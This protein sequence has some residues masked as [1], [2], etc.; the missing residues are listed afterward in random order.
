MTHTAIDLPRLPIGDWCAAVVLWA[1]ENLGPILDA[2]YSVLRAL[3]DKLAAG[4]H[5]V[6]ALLMAVIL[7]LVAWAASSWKLG[8]GTLL[9]MLLISTMGMWDEAMD[10]L[11]LVIVCSVVAMAFALPI[12][13]A[14]ARYE[15]VSHVV[16]PVLDF[17]QTLPVFVYLIPAVLLFGI[18]V[19]PGMVATIVFAMPPG[20][21]LTEL[22]IRQVDR[23]VV[24][25][26]H[27]FGAAP[28]RIL[29]RIQVPLAMPTIMAGVNQVIM[30]ALS[31]VVVAGMVGAG[32]LG[33]LVYQGITTMDMPLGF[34]GG[35]AVVILAMFLD[36][37]T[38]GLAGRSPV[39]RV[40]KATARA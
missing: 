28:R 7:G 6:P 22:G 38:A 27:A 13:V 23:E 3:D 40:S 4:L 1:Q 39:A 37:I 32:G 5:V 16:R 30:L 29:T 14:A 20:V 18:G 31:M 2:I 24:E 21:R 25:A 26:G 34:E 9:G 36:R 35:I 8:V 19:V 12:G 17:M 15:A 33:A 11:S 10:T